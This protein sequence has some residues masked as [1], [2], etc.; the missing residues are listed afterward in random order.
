MTLRIWWN[1]EHGCVC[2]SPNR[3]IRLAVTLETKKNKRPKI[4]KRVSCCRAC[5]CMWILLKC[6]L[7]SYAEC[8]YI[9]LSGLMR[10]LSV[11]MTISSEDFSPFG[12]LPINYTF[13]GQNINP[14]LRFSGIPEDAG[15]LVL[16]VRDPDAPGSEVRSTK[17]IHR[18]CFYGFGKIAS[19]VPIVFYFE[20]GFRR[21]SR[22]K[23][24]TF[25]VYIGSVYM[26]LA[27]P[28]PPRRW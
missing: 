5:S 24:A 4:P 1:T 11:G 16:I 19:P 9:L 13:F 22:M 12:V 3:R 23:F 25:S 28:P 2:S 18:R 14:E 26:E 15:S 10:C 21:T 17:W 20:S 6:I 7:N 27:N 8:T